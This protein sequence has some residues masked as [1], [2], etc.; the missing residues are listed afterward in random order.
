MNGWCC[1]SFC[2]ALGVRYDFFL[3]DI[4]VKKV[5]C[6]IMKPMA[7]KAVAQAGNSSMHDIMSDGAV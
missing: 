1:E 7:A 3:N 4:L 6:Y 2:F 5:H